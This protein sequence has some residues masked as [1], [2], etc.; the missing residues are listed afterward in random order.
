MIESGRH[1]KIDCRTMSGSIDIVKSK[2]ILHRYLICSFL[3]GDMG[4]VVNIESVA[5]PL[6]DDVKATRFCLIELDREKKQTKLMCGESGT[7]MRFMLPLTAALGRPAELILEG[8][9]ISRP[10]SELKE[11]LCT[12]GAEI[13][14]EG[15]KIF[16]EGKIEPGI[17]E[18]PGNI[19]SQYISGLLLALSTLNENSRIIVKG[20]SKSEPYI[21]LTRDVMKKFGIST[22]REECDNVVNYSVRGGQKYSVDKNQESTMENILE[23]DWSA[24][25]MWL[26]ANESLDGSIDIRGLKKDSVQ[27]DRVI[28]DILNGFKDVTSRS[29]NKRLEFN[30]SDCPDI[31][32]AVA[33]RAVIAD[34]ET[35]TMISQIGTLR[36]K[37]S[38]RLSA[39]QEIL[40]KLG[41]KIRIEEDSLVISGSGGSLTGTE[42]IIDVRRDHRMAMLA[43]MASV[44]TEKPVKINDADCVNKSYPGFWEDIRKSG[45]KIDIL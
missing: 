38:D 23:G 32:P 7:T 36:Y 18:V 9:L 14:S 34:T 12:H 35:E 15:N 28:V 19:S 41:G 11:S 6:S 3:S 17:Y 43:A 13:S 44:V 24:G 39:I 10:F 16:V 5:G 21:E 26:V 29:N 45:G 37:E 31:V 8:S 25:A 1:L 33:L 2:S 42:E 27:G 40:S 30:L 22:L 20:E 4:R